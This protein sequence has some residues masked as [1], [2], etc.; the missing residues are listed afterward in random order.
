MSE[1]INTRGAY[2]AFHKHLL[3]G[4]SA[5]ALTL[6][7]SSTS[8]AAEDADRPTVWIELGGQ[9]EM[10]QGTTNPFVA[11]FM[12]LSP[13]PS[14][15]NDVPFIDSQKPA[16]FSF[17]AEGKLSFQ[18]EGSDWIFSAGLRYGRSNTKRHVHH[19]SKAPPITFSFSYYGNTYQYT[20]YPSSQM[21][22][23]AQADYSEQHVVVDFSAGRDVGIGMFGRNGT[24][25]ISGGVRFASF[26][27][28]ST[29]H[30]TAR[31]E[32]G[33]VY[34]SF[35]GIRFPRFT[36]H[37]YTMVAAAQRS[38][39]GVGPSLSWQASAV[40]LGNADT[41]ELSFDW[42]VNAALLFGK[43]KAKTSHV[44]EARNHLNYAS[45]PVTSYDPHHDTRS[46]SVVIP[47]LGGF[48]GLSVKYP[49]AKVAIGYRA[50]FFFGAMDTGIDTRS[51]KDVGFHGPFA[52]VSIG[53]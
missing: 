13:V 53:L 18:P 30:M 15:Y 34:Q 14:V 2:N 9:M 1:L 37:Q 22:A 51:I 7:I 48:A 42:G 23:D 20:K 11:P 26:V 17:G 8:L 24:S 6:Y 49:N 50:D 46:R 5:L 31:P 16:H 36:Y 10:V 12:A 25:V 52:T 47:N 41:S 43:Q 21:L 44:T 27:A 38:F 33:T 28:H 35:Y 19:Q 45:F 32:I 29:A 4:A 40:L 39:H 3:A